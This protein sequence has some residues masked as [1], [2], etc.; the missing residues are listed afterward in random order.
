MKGG[1]DITDIREIKMA[2]EAGSPDVELLSRM[3]QV[4]IPVVQ[5]YV[6]FFSGN[7]TK[8]VEAAPAEVVEDEKPRKRSRIFLDE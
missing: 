7:T 8:A 6:D 4:P 5:S 3:L 2:V 1:A